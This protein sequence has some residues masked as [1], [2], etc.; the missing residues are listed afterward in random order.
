MS[1]GIVGEGKSI[2]HC[3]DDVTCWH[4]SASFTDYTDKLRSEFAMLELP[5]AW[6]ILDCTD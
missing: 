1:R 6:G 3:F 4:W 2:D 5:K